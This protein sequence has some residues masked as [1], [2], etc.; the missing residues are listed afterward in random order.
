MSKRDKLGIW[1]KIEK[2]CLETVQ[3]II[4]ASIESKLTKITTLNTA[5]TKVELLKRLLR[6]TSELGIIPA[7]KYLETES[8]LQE[9][10]KMT[11]GWIKYLAAA[12]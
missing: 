9:I 2:T 3:L 7:G 12:Q 11:N 4:T 8:D 5:R 1:L 10:S 6:I